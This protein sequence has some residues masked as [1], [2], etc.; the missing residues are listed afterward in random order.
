MAQQTAK[1]DMSS[2][3]SDENGMSAVGCAI[4]LGGDSVTG[5]GRH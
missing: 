1:T 4:Q 3:W 2:D 5:I